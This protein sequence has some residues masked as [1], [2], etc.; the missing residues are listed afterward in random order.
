[1]ADAADD[2]DLVAKSVRPVGPQA[3]PR[4]SVSTTCFLR[5]APLVSAMRL[6]S[7]I[8]PAVANDL[9]LDQRT[10]INASAASRAQMLPKPI[11]AM[12]LSQARVGRRTASGREV[13]EVSG[14]DELW[15]GSPVAP[16]NTRSTASKYRVYDIVRLTAKAIQNRDGIDRPGKNN[17]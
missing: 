5:V 14:A 13:E 10:S 9:V 3:I 15:P 4:T 16:E 2:R 6:I 1:M 11:N 12:R 17:P 7:T 8:P